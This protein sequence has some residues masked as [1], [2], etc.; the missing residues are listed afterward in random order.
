MLGMNY[1]NFEDSNTVNL[2]LTG[3]VTV[4]VITFALYYF[5][6]T[7]IEAARGKSTETFVVAPP[8]LPFGMKD[9]NAEDK[10]MNATQYDLSKFNEMVKQSIIGLCIIS[11]IYYKWESPKPLFLQMIMAP[12]T[13]LES[14][15]FQ[16]HVLNKPAEGKLKRPWAPAPGM[17]DAINEA[18]AK[19]EAA[20]AE[21]QE[22][23][24]A[25]STTDAKETKPI[26]ESAQDE[27]CP[28]EEADQSK[29]EEP[30]VDYSTLEQVD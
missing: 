25:Q 6:Y 11:L 5:V 22:T 8:S 18:K 24:Q 28:A 23:E 29:E 26:E 1:L 13:L 16:L 21:A 17:F 14:E 20:A 12:M 10:I 3:Y 30:A 15:L 2:V 4:Q 9:P 27:G 19:A 7:K